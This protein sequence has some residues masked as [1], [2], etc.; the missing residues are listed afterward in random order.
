MFLKVSPRRGLLSFG[1]KGKLS[2]RFIGPFEI[3][4]R[5][6]EVAYRLA[7]PLQFSQVHNVF[8]VLMLR[9]YQENTS[10]VLDWKK[11]EVDQDVTYEEQPLRIIERTDR[12]LRGRMIPLVRVQWNHHDVKE[13]TWEIESEMR[14]R[15]PH[16]VAV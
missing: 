7:F 14:S 3:L 16:L 6:G 5:V 9:K 12:T 1:K 2:P 13:L 8:H 10:H 4:D 15:Y 11:I